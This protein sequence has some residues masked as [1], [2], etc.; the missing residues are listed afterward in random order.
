VVATGLVEGAVAGDRIRRAVPL[1][2]VG[3]APPTGLSTVLPLGFLLPNSVQLSFAWLPFAK[4]QLHLGSF[5][6]HKFALAPP[7]SLSMACQKRSLGLPQYL[8]P[9]S[10]IPNNARTKTQSG[11][12]RRGRGFHIVRK[13]TRQQ[14]SEPGR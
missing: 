14:Q 12:L 4:L 6:F 10:Q 3:C 9:P 7:K 1:D 5:T 8:V 13:P 2:I 11:M